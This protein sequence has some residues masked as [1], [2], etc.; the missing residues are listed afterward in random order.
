MNFGLNGPLPPLRPAR[1][2]GPAQLPC[3]PAPSPLARARRAS[4][5]GRVST[6]SPRGRRSTS[7]A[8]GWRLGGSHVLAHA[9]SSHSTG[10]TLPTS[11][12]VSISSPLASSSRGAVADAR[13][14]ARRRR[15]ATTARPHERISGQFL[16]AAAPPRLPPSGAHANSVA[17]AQVRPNS[18]VRPPRA[19]WPPLGRR[20]GRDPSAITSSPISTFS[21]PPSS[22]ESVAHFTVPSRGRQ[23]RRTPPPRGHAVEDAG[24]PWSRPLPPLSVR[25]AERPWAG[26]QAG[27]ARLLSRA[28]ARAE[29]HSRP[30]DFTGPAR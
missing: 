6:H 24:I 1:A 30:V 8:Y 3:S 21:C 14:S 9:L 26:A 7:P 29:S 20:C 19:P 27:P 15:S 28:R 22:C 23:R 18:V 2:S 11:P 10:F 12:P 16:S 17:R 13:A 25:W 4:A 5:T